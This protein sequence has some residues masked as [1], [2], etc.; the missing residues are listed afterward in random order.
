MDTQ[1]QTPPLPQP[2][3]HKPKRQYGKFNKEAY[4]KAIEEGLK[5]SD[6]GRKAG[7]TAQNDTTV[8]NTV[9]YNLT[10]DGDLKKGVLQR[11]EAL[12][13][14]LLGAIEEKDLSKAQVSQLIVST[15]IVRDKIQLMSGQETQRIGIKPIIISET[16]DSETPTIKIEAPK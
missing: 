12:E 14:K 2:A 7:L 15:A 4:L 8:I 5:V 10:R 6:A 16:P 11:Y 1:T 3:G 9:N 13:R